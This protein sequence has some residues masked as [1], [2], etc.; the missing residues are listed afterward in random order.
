MAPVVC[1]GLAFTNVFA[2]LFPGISEEL[3]LETFKAILEVD[4]LD[5]HQVVS[6]VAASSIRKL[7][8][9][10]DDR[11]VITT[12]IR[13]QP[14]IS[15]SIDKCVVAACGECWATTS[16]LHFNITS[17]NLVADRGT[18][19]LN[20]ID[21][22]RVVGRPTLLST[23]RRVDGV[24]VFVGNRSTVVVDGL[25]YLKVGNFFSALELVLPLGLD[26]I[27]FRADGVHIKHTIFE[28]VRVEDL[29]PR[30]LEG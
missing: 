11:R 5:I 2:P 25:S 1:T 29:L 23:R 16:R 26:R 24:S 21:S 15:S 27:G 9:N 10:T 18:V 17:R 6:T 7:V 19:I 28:R 12:H 20:A 22:S 8:R 3:N 13:R 4:F 30:C 14:G